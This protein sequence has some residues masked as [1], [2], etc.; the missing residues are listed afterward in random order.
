MDMVSS[1]NLNYLTGSNQDRLS[2]DF[3]SNNQK[4]R[5]E[6][7]YWTVESTENFKAG[8]AERF[9]RTKQNET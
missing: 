4:L 9:S 8:W 7:L 6:K 5:T 1:W 3:E 2:D